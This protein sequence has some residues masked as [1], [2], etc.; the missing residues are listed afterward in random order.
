M[1][2]MI[3]HS[4]TKVNQCGRS[5]SSH[6]C[7]ECLWT[8]IIL[9]LSAEN[10]NG[11]SVWGFESW[12]PIFPHFIYDATTT[13]CLIRQIIYLQGT[14][15]ATVLLVDSSVRQKLQ[16]ED[17]N[18]SLWED[19]GKV[20]SQS[21]AEKRKVV[22][23]R[24][25]KQDRFSLSMMEGSFYGKLTTDKWAKINKCTPIYRWS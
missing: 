22:P 17:F 24:F 23:R 13:E 25:M 3:W 8:A 5:Y 10:S 21:S 6:F 7:D 12:K 1:K 18:L 11:K 15:D 4:D 9:C 14:L 20:P 2:S 16:A 19:G